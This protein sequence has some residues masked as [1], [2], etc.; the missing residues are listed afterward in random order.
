M[1]RRTTKRKGIRN[2]IRR[3]RNKIRRKLMKNRRGL[4]YRYLRSQRSPKIKRKTRNPNMNISKN[5]DKYFIVIT[6]QKSLSL[7][8]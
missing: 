4:K 5:I 2:N 3:N 1:R 7:F 8:P 6:I